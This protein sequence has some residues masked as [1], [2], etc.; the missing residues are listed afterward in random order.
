MGA[1]VRSLSTPPKLFFRYKVLTYI[2]F[3]GITNIYNLRIFTK[4]S[5]KLARFA[6]IVYNYIRIVVI[7]MKSILKIIMVFMVIFIIFMQISCCYAINPDE[8]DPSKD[9]NTSNEKKLDDKAEKVVGI[10]RG[11]GIIV[12]VASLIVIGIREITS[13]AAEKSIIRQAMPGYIIGAIMVFAISMIPT[14]IYNV[15]K[16]IK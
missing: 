13:S 1:E 11:I 6:K 9:R 3:Y 5:Q 4:F 14:I 12:S 10:I 8:Y 2:F 15:T 16:D 7:N